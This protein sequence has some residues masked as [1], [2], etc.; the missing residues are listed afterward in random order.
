MDVTK[1][2]FLQILRD[3][4]VP[5]SEIDNIG[6]NKDSPL[7]YCWGTLETLPEG[8][9][10]EHSYR[11]LQRCIELVRRSDLAV[12]TKD[13]VSVNDYLILWYAS[14]LHDIAK[15]RDI[16]EQIKANVEAECKLFSHEKSD[17]GV[18]SAHHLNQELKKGKM[19]FYGLDSPAIE[20]VL[21]VISFH[22]SGDMHPCFLGSGELTRKELLF[23]LAFWLADIADGAD[24]RV[25]ATR[26]MDNKLQSSKTKARR[27]V[28]EVS[29]EKG[30][31][32]WWVKKYD[33]AARDASD[34]E[35]K[36][37]SKHRLLLQA[38]GLPSEIICLE[39]GMKVPTKE[40]CL[41][42]SDIRASNL[43]LDVSE[44]VPPWCFQLIPCPNFTKK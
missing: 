36:K 21:N 40:A 42:Y 30:Y 11:V 15:S 12:S 5:G 13:T 2:D 37:L 35:N 16:P 10:P 3:L 6:K 27:T 17:H 24:Y 39:Q 7:N 41:Q 9:V 26:T 1:D 28:K 8:N 29:I 25:P 31:I 43:C 44:R 33:D 38:F 32:V 20:Q 4:D 34:I 18:R 19:Q 23:C 22:S 14:L